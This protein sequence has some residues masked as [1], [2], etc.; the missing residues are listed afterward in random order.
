MSCPRSLVNQLAADEQ[1]KTAAPRAQ[2]RRKFVRKGDGAAS[3][4]EEGADVEMEGRDADRLFRLAREQ[5]SEEAPKRAKVATVLGGD[6]D[7]DD[8]GEDDDEEDSEGEDAYDAGAA[9]LEVL[10]ES[11]ERAIEA[12][13]GAGTRR[14]LADIISEKLAAREQQ[15]A[16]SQRVTLSPQVVEVYTSVGALLSRYRAGKI[17]KAFKLIPALRDWEEVL[18]LTNPAKWSPQALRAATRLF[19]SNLSPKMAQRYYALI[20]LPSVRD[21]IRDNGRLNYHRYMALKKAL[22]KPAAFFKGLLLPLCSDGD[23]TLKE[24]T[25]IGSVLQKVSVPVVHAGAAMVKMASL[26]YSGA[27]CV[28]MRVLV[29]KKYALPYKVVD[30]LVDHFCSFADDAREMP[31]LWHQG[32]LALAQRYRTYFSAEQ[33][34]RLKHLLKAKPHKKLTAEIRRELFAPAS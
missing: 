24:A 23:C 3:E 12:F 18:F 8:G 20:L 34:E 4:D 7:D 21:D 2:P 15:D 27:T 19:A 6:N 31:V 11:D 22:Y 16:G 29:D 28:F 9:E 17:P 14:T 10:S 25:I 32:L 13:M 5:A 1:R 30:V 26:P 33:K